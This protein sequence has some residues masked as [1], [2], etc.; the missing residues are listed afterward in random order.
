LEEFEITCETRSPELKIENLVNILVAT[1]WIQVSWKLVWKFVLM[2]SRSS[3]NIGYLGKKLGH[4]AQIWI[5]LVNTVVVT[6]LTHLS[7]NLVRMLVLVIVRMSLM[8]QVSDLG[9]SWPSCLFLGV[10]S[11]YL[12]TTTLG[13]RP[14]SRPHKHWPSSINDL[15]LQDQNS[16][17]CLFLLLFAVTLLFLNGLSSNLNIIIFKDIPKQWP[18]RPSL[19]NDL[20]LEGQIIKIF[21]YL[22]VTGCNIVFFFWMDCLQT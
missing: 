12:V 19:I 21:I 17:F 10:L 3:L 6:F 13:T 8:G 2:I 1:V 5:I 4:T 16:K 22:A 9:P 20:D 7:W 18:D 11:S 15:D 14:F